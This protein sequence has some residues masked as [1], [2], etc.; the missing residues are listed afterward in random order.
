MIRIRRNLRLEKLNLSYLVSKISFLISKYKTF[1]FTNPLSLIAQKNVLP[2]H[3]DAFRNCRAMS[4]IKFG[5]L[6][7]RN[8]GTFDS[9]QRKINPM[10]KSRGET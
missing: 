2:K 10:N 7:H 1:P 5:M 4:L 8:G 6:F 3:C 9:Q